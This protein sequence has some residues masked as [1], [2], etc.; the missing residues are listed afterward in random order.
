M[1]HRLAARLSSWAF[2]LI[3]VVGVAHA[4]GLDGIWC[5]PDGR[6]ITV[7][8][9]DVITPGGQR[10]TGVYRNDDFA[11]SVPKTARNAGAVIW[12]ELVSENTARVSIVSKEQREPPPHGLW[13]R[14]AYTS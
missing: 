7:D 12:M 1:G 10:T 9:L 2:L 11:F 14:C 6:R 3:V 4:D 13:Q 5:S 8:G